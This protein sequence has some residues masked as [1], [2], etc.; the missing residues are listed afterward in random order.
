MC[1]VVGLLLRD[2][3]LEPQLGELLVPMIE[4]LDERGPDSSGIAVYADRRRA[5]AARATAAPCPLSLGADVRST[6]WPSAAPC[7]TCA[8][9]APSSIASGP[10]S[11]ST[12]PRAPRR[13]GG[14]LG[15]EWPAVRV[16]GTGHHS[17]S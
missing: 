1:G 14:P 4:A 16:L 2:P 12:S 5:T 15:R 3:A 9:R 13:R 8:P 10:D 11:S 17:A 7:S 6:G